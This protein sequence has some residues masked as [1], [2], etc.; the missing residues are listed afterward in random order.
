MQRGFFSLQR[1]LGM[2]FFALLLL[3]SRAV[4][5]ETTL[6]MWHAYRAEEKRA[7]EAVMEA[8]HKKQKK[9]RVRLLAIPYDAYADKISAAIPRGHGPDLFIFAHDRIGDWA[10]N[11]IL[12]PITFWVDEALLGQFFPKTL[13]VLVYKDALY[14]LPLAFKSL[15]LYY[16]KTLV[17]EPPRDTQTL[18]KLA[19][20]LTDAKA[21]R[22]GLA[23]EAGNFYHHAAWLHGFGGAVF[24]GGKLVIDSEASARALAFAADLQHKHALLPAEPTSQLVSSLFN[25]G[26]AAMVLNGPWF[27]GEI[28][29]KIDYGVIPMPKVN[30][31]GRPAAPFLTSEAVLLNR[32]GKQKRLAFEVMK[33][34]TSKE[35]AMIRMTVGKQPV[36][37][38]ACYDTPE[39]KRDPVLMAFRKQLDTAIPM[40]NTPQMRMVWSP[41]LNALGKVFRK[42]GTP[43]EALREASKEILSYIQK[44]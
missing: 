15:A 29:A 25:Q 39:A 1:I 22:F 20:S 4:F 2:V 32:Q 41:I 11:K 7:L 9:I 3:V 23:Y 38:P 31:T 28:D 21:G 44:K 6:V 34:L 5:A 8:Y 12:E 27:R 37:N 43:Q 42:Q 26:K 16:N 19:Q 18:I 36:A 13:Q 14:G 17:K 35:A 30:E 24:K 33:Y 40:D 10:Q